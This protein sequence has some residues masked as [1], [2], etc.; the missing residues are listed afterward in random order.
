MRERGVEVLEL[1]EML[2]ETLDDQAARDWVLDRRITGNDLGSAW[3]P[4]SAPWLDEMPAAKL[5]E[6]L[7]GGIAILDLPKSEMSTLL[8][9]AYGGTDF[10]LPPMPNT[11]F[12]RDPSCWIYKGVTC[13]PMFWPARQP[14]TLLQ[15]AVYK[16]HPRFK[17]ADFKIWWGDSDER[18]G[19]ST[20]EGGDVMPIGKGVVLIG[21][22]ERTTR[23]AV[24]QVAD[25]LFRQKARRRA[26]SAA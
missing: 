8:I 16:F 18:F 9:E 22:G 11:L 19:A 7:I 2:A 23:Q 15:R 20:V 17:G 12:Q 5:A 6:H 13:N 4:R 1:H 24:Y 3:P 26:S 14:E 10:L 21:M 25:Q